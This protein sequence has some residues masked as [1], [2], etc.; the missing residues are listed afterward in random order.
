MGS[1]IIGFRVP[2]DLA[3]EIEKVSAEKGQ[4]VTEFLRKLVDEALYPSKSTA[5]LKDEDGDEITLSDVYNEVQ[6]HESNIQEHYSDIAKLEQSLKTLGERL[7][8]LV[9]LQDA[10]TQSVIKMANDLNDSQRKTLSELT[11]RLNNHIVACNG[12]FD[13][14]KTDSS[15]ITA[16]EESLSAKLKKIESDLEEVSKV[17]HFNDNMPS[18][19]EF[20]RLERLVRKLRDMHTQG[21]KGIENGEHKTVFVI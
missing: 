4:T 12:W 20:R 9:K 17:A 3:E 7:D 1:K 13:K 19:E 14:E 10:D 8:A 18:L 5:T 16:L 21:E 15:R 6:G 11:V 2:D